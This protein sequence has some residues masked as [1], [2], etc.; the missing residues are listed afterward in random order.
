ML[1]ENM[2][3]EKYVMDFLSGKLGVP[4]YGQSDDATEKVFLVIEKTG[5]Y[6]SNKIEHATLAVQSYAGSIAES[7]KLNR[8]VIKAMNCIIENDAISSISLN[9]DYNYT[10]TS[11]KKYRYQAV[12]DITYFGYKL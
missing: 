5:S 1:I 10:D 3:I 8:K 11:L 9:S 2:L 12:F 4:A 7:A 6:T